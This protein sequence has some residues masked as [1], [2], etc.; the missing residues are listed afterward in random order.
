MA[1]RIRANEPD[2]TLSRQSQLGAATSEAEVVALA[3]EFLASVSPYDLARIPESFRPEKLVDGNDITE[4]AVRL[5]RYDCDD[6][7]G[8]ARC[9]RRL[10]NFFSSASIQLSKLMAR[11][12]ESVAE[13]PD[14][15]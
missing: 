2:A 1:P 7:D 15:A 10:A 14:S 6:A 12:N 9:I 11:N 3:R 5:V 4:Y 8:N 13:S